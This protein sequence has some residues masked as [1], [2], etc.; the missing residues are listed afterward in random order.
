[1][2]K[3]V[4]GPRVAVPLRLQVLIREIIEVIRVTAATL[5]CTLA[6]E[7]PMDRYQS[8]ISRY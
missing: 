4:R 5:N 2:R 1:M 8:L 6:V 3:G 7:A